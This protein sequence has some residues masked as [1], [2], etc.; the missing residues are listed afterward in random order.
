M[1]KLIVL[2]IV[3]LMAVA[4]VGANTLK[5]KAPAN[6]NDIAAA[7]WI[8]YS[9]GTEMA[10]IVAT[11]TKV[12][13]VIAGLV[14]CE[15]SAGDIM[16]FGAAAGA[17]GGGWVIQAGTDGVACIIAVCSGGGKTTVQ[18]NLLTGKVDPTFVKATGTGPALAQGKL[19]KL[20]EVPEGV[21]ERLQ[22]LVAFNKN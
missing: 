10:T 7:G 11:W 19:V 9:D 17:T 3:A 8:P 5:L 21:K 1:R 22:K 18:V 15:D 13:R 12:S 4:P 2:T 16:T 14:L 6:C 20:N